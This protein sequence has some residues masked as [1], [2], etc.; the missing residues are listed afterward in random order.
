MKQP[1]SLLLLLISIL[2]ISAQEK[3]IDTTKI[4][5]LKEVVVTGQ[6]NP[7]SVERSVFEVKVISRKDIDLQAG[8]NLADLLNQQLNINIIPNATT[9]K[10]G[11]QLFGLDARYFKVLIDNIPV[12]NDEGLGNQTDLTQ[13]NLDDIERI[14]IVEGSMG[15]Q[16]GADAVS[17]IVN[18]ITKKSAEDNWEI[19]PYVQEETINDEYGFFDQGRHIQSVSIAHNINKELYANG[20]FT[21]NQFTGYSGDKLGENHNLNDG[22]RGY[23]WLPKDQFHAKALLNYSSEKINSFYKFE[24]FDETVSRYDS[25]VRMNYNPSTQT[26]NPTVSDEIFHSTRFVHHLN[27]NGPLAGLLNYDISISYQ[28]QKRDVETYNYRIN[29]E[30]KFDVASFEYES[31]KGFYS[32]GNFTNFIK[33]PKYGLQLGYEISE[34]NGY[35]STLSGD[36]Q[37]DYISRMLGSYDVF[38]SFEYSPGKRFS[39]RPGGRALFSSNFNPQLALSLSSKYSFANDLE[40]RTVIGTAPRL[41]GYDELYTYF[42]DINHDVRGNENLQPEQGVSLFMHLKKPLKFTEGSLRL[43]NKLS[44]WYID[45]RDRIELIIVNET[46]LA[47]QYRNIDT[48]RTW[49]LSYNNSVYYKNLRFNAGISYTGVSKVL[50]SDENYDDDYLY[51][52][53]LNSSINYSIPAWKM[54]WSAYFKYN[55]PQYQ[56]VQKQDNDNNTIIVRGKQDSYSWLDT[57]IKKSLLDNKLELTLGARNLLDITR[58]NTTATNGGAHTEAPSNVLLGYGRSYFLKLLYNLNI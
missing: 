48:Y 37:G 4:N 23:I 2:S 14:E 21:R 7:Q 10:S 42:V 52:L 47:Y 16:Y 40:L 53:Q 19:R 1:T 12:I 24:Y 49:G 22:K 39:I 3:S 55:G 32:K 11:V 54:V 43:Q 41:P 9:G 56:F 46:P 57:S 34:I 33:D 36:Y 51:A 30:E 50:N 5:T 15:V 25:V 26:N 28:Q 8:N 6:I 35:A 58:V 27:L 29:S 44:A 31:R 45:V 13:I 20:V 18:I 38:T 17:G